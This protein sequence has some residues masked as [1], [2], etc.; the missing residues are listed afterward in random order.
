[1]FVWCLFDGVHL[2]HGRYKK[3]PVLNSGYFLCY[4][5]KVTMEKVMAETR[6]SNKFIAE[7]KHE[8]LTKQLAEEKENSKEL[9]QKLF[10]VGVALYLQ[11]LELDW[12]KRHSDT[13]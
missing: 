12:L 10:D 9:K 3:I 11:T 1:M 2:I 13:Q 4:T 6:D 8:L 7:S 5:I